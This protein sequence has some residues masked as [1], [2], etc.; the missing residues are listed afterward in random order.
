MMTAEDRSE[1]D[2]NIGAIT[3]PH[4]YDYD[5]G[6]MTDSNVAGTK[7]HTIC[8]TAT[9]YVKFSQSIGLAT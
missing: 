3:A 2:F 5:F 1:N 8:I 9:Y 6:V 4:V 7:N